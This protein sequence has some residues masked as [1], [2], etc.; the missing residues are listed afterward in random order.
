MKMYPQVLR[1]PAKKPIDIAAYGCITRLAA[2]PTAT[3]PAKVAFC[4]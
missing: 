1:M 2:V 3:P 4:T